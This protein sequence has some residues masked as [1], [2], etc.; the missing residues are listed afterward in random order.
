VSFADQLGLEHPI[1]QAGMGGGIATSRLAGA[2]SAAGGLGTVGILPPDLLKTEL[3]SAMDQA[4]GRPVSANLLV[5]FATAA[6]VRVCHEVRAPVVVLHGGFDKSLIDELRSGGSLVL[7]TVG[8][9]EEASRA[10]ADGADGLIVQGVEAG[11]HL[12]GVEPAIDALERVRERAKDVPLLV[13]GGIAD[14]ADVKRALDAG[15]TAAVA[16]TR[17]L[18]TDES[19][20]HPAYKER[21]LRADRTLHT[22]LFGLGWPMRHRVVPNAATERWCRRN[23]FGPPAVLA[24]QRV[25]TPLSRLPMSVAANMVRTQIPAIP[26]FG[27]ATVVEGMPEKSVDSTALYAGETALRIDSIL[28]AAQALA[29]LAAA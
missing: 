27:P 5:P 28:P 7:Q 8:T 22:R 13:A 4:P 20:A 29:K 24:F 21:V 17:F 18:L 14:H 11:G 16:G 6:H 23:E 15:A 26:L 2:V 19:A 9:P 12:V 3:R 10:L 1:V 25:T